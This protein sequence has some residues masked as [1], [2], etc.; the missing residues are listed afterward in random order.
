MKR[1][2]FRLSAE[3]LSECSTEFGCRCIHVWLVFCD[4]KRYNEIN[5]ASGETRVGQENYKT[6]HNLI[7]KTPQ[8][9]MVR[10]YLALENAFLHLLGLDPRFTIIMLSE[11][12]G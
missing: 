4:A 8:M 5:A 6:L 12:E 10:V 3:V 11:R 9:R 1:E 7:E 2:L